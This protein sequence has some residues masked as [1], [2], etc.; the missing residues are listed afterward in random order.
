MM[1]RRPSVLDAQLEG[2]DYSSHHPS[3]RLGCNETARISAGIMGSFSARAG[4]EFI[5]AKAR[6]LAIRALRRQGL[7]RDC[8]RY[9][10]HSLPGY[11]DARGAAHWSPSS[12]GD[13]TGSGCLY[14][15]RCFG[16]E[17]WS[18]QGW[19]SRTFGGGPGLRAAAAVP[20]VCRSKLLHTGPA[21]QPG[22]FTPP[23]GD[24]GLVALSVVFCK[25]S[26]RIRGANLS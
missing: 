4:D 7:H 1:S 15:L 24:V 18:R 14:H 13:W 11:R 2:N 21:T 20:W 9:L 8:N 12:A 17:D 10:C 23:P 19:I 3:S 16:R 5:I 25:H 22:K 6:W 26:T